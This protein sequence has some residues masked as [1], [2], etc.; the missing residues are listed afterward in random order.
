[1]KFAEEFEGYHLPNT[2]NWRPQLT[3]QRSAWSRHI[4][5]SVMQEEQREVY[6]HTST[7]SGEYQDMAA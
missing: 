5:V 3:K 1:M 6:S 4:P 2:P 7:V